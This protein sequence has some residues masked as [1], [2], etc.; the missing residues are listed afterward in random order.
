MKKKHLLKQDRPLGLQSMCTAVLL[1][2]G[3][4]ASPVEAF[5][6][7]ATNLGIEETMQTFKVRGMVVDKEQIPVIGAT[8]MVEGT[9]KGTI[10]DLEGNY[11]LEV[12]SKDCRLVV[13]YIGYTTQTIN[14]QGRS[15]ITVTLSEENFNIDEVVVVGYNTVKR[16]QI[17][18]AVDMVKSEK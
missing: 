13:S 9:T 15:T 4:C 12:P 3:L 1:C 8:V 16:G 2:G 7:N 5:A 11:E 6:V 17:T 14:V 10:T 18:G